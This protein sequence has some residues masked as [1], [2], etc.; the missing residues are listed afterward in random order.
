LIQ[1]EV[2]MGRSHAS[3]ISVV[4]AISIAAS[5]FAFGQSFQDELANLRSPNAKTRVKAAKTLGDSQR[6]EAIQPLIEAMR[7][8]EAKVRKA[9][10]AALRQYRNVAT[11]DGLLVGLADEEKNIRSDSM[12]GV[13]E[14]YVS[15]EKRRP[16][17]GLFTG[18]K[19]PDS[20]EPVTPPVEKVIRALETRVGDEDPSIRKRAVYTLGVL[21]SE[22]SVGVLVRAL[23]DTNQSVRSEAVIALGRVGT[24]AAGQALI[25]ALADSS[26]ETRRH[27]IDALGHM[28]YTPAARALLNVYEAEKG[29]AMSDR[30]LSALAYMG[31]PEA[32]GV[33]FQNLTDSSTTRRRYAV[34]GLGRLDDKNLMPGLTKD[35][36][37][38][39]DETVQL[40]YCFSIARL[41]RPEFI[42]RLALS[43]SKVDQ[44]EQARKYLVDLGSPFLSE[45]TPYLSDPVTEVRKGMVQVLMD[46]GD[47]AAIPYLEPLLMDTDA[48]VADLANRAIARLQSSPMTASIK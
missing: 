43:L 22:S 10:V 18:Q 24:D 7:D 35:F 17:L 9:V 19:L 21:G 41:G 15:D 4:A 47:P 29:K 6:P 3:L 46:I 34:E 44:R 14:L 27:A 31:A 12:D 37:R 48:Q 11:V 32:R 30:A 13:I 1:G 25:R 33:F 28:K 36:L 26:S 42:D 16:L 8:P 45:F 23:P 5:S 38:E 40:A 20:V 39:P 2:T